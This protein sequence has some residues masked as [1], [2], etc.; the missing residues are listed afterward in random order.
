MPGHEELPLDG[1]APRRS[2]S[3]VTDRSTPRARAAETGGLGPEVELFDGVR[4]GSLIIIP[5]LSTSRLTGWK[6]LATGR[7]ALLDRCDMAL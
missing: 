7:S 2:K 1:T 4:L 3:D 6:P 5:D